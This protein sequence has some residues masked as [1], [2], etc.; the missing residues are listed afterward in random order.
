MFPSNVV[1]HRLSES[2]DCQSH[3]FTVLS[4]EA[5]ATRSPFVVASTSQIRLR[6]PR[7]VVM[8][9]DVAVSQILTVL[10]LWD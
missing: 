7:M 3:T 1:A 8:Q 4:P 9:L 5:E 6:C 2:S 10:S